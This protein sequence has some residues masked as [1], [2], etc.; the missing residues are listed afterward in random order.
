MCTGRMSIVHCTLI[1][2]IINAI[3]TIIYVV[4]ILSLN[5]HISENNLLEDSRQK[6]LFTLNTIG[7]LRD[8]WKYVYKKRSQTFV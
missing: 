7:T 5:F 1:F 3:D 2:W 6:R 8:K 4:F